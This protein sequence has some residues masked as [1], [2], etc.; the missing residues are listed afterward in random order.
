MIKGNKSP[1]KLNFH[2]FWTK[3][4]YFFSLEVLSIL[5]LSLTFYIKVKAYKGHRVQNEQ[6]S[7]K[8]LIVFSIIW[9]FKKFLI[10]WDFHKTDIYLE[11]LFYLFLCGFCIINTRTVLLYRHIFSTSI[12]FHNFALFHWILTVE[13]KACVNKIL[14]EIEKWSKKLL[15]IKSRIFILFECGLVIFSAVQ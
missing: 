11:A 15:K 9:K 4:L 5:S 1:K 6:I 14:N 7:Q 3:K 13:R 12:R 2:H 10:H 8:C